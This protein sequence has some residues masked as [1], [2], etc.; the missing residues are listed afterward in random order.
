MLDV[1]LDVGVSGACDA[2][3]CDVWRLV[4]GSVV[5]SVMGGVRRLVCLTMLHPCLYRPLMSGVP[6]WYLSRIKWAKLV[7][8]TPVCVEEVH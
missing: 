5:V 6:L 2:L 3:L 1:N 7:F 8:G 4:R